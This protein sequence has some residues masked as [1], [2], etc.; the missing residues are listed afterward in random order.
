MKKVLIATTALVAS[1]G[2]AAADV[3]LSG[4]GRLGVI[5]NDSDSDAEFTSRARVSFT[6]SGETDGGI[7]FGG[8]FRADNASSASGGTAG[9]VFVSGDFG[10]LSMGDVDSAAK[11]AVGNISGVGLTGLNDTHELTY[12]SGSDT[13]GD[14]DTD[15]LA[16]LPQA[17]YEYSTGAFAFYLSAGSPAGSSET[18]TSA[19]FAA[20][21]YTT[22]T[23][24]TD[25]VYGVGASYSGDNWKVGAGWETADITVS[26]ETQTIG[27]APV[28][29]TTVSGSVDAWY[30]GGEASFGDAT[31]KANYGDGDLIQQ[32]GISLD[33]VFGATTLTAFYH[34]E[35]GQGVLSGTD[36]EAYGVGASYDLG[37]GASLVGGYR[38]AN[39]DDKAD[40]GIK[41]NF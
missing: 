12:L 23:L 39:D 1:A 4:D 24:S 30:I 38:R 7:A 17:L 41:F 25:N 9:S 40:F 32:W 35:E 28:G 8:S 16:P 27:L 21:T 37:G 22:D 33:Y 11:A 14:G 19:D 3:A 13:D 31:V 36:Y 10:K 15:F 2:F 5:F 6:L 20:G 18:T 34:D 26:T 29:P